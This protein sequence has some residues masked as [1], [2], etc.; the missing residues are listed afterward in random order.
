LNFTPEVSE[1]AK[2]DAAYSPKAVIATEKY[3]NRRELNGKEARL[4]LVT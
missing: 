1:V 2:P 4:K 3:C